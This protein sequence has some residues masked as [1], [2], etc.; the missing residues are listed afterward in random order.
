[1]VICARALMV[2]LC[3]FLLCGC[4]GQ[5]V[6][7]VKARENPEMYQRVDRVLTDSR[8]VINPYPIYRFQFAVVE[9]KIPNAWVN[10]KKGILVVTTGLLQMCDDNELALIFLH[11]NAH[12]KYDHAAKNALLSDA[13]SA[14]F[15]IA[16]LF[17]P[18]VGYGNLIVNP[19][20]TSGYSRSQELEADKD[21][22][23]QCHFLR[24][25]PDHYVSAL[26]KMKQY[27]ASKGKDSDS[28][29]LFDTHPNLQYRIDTINKMTGK[30]R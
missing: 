10:T 13:T 25:N 28:T 21:V 4:A 27:A 30:T 11:E 12:I 16:G 7:Y 26:E 14:A 8:R 15:T 6:K 5:K 23:D 1:M 2:V 18:G 29:G 24:L 19:L 17:L 22:I 20:V 3:L 9:D